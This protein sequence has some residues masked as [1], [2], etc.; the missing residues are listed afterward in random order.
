MRSINFKKLNNTA[1]YDGVYTKCQNSKTHVLDHSLHFASAV[2][3]GIRIYNYKAFKLHEHIK[4]FR[5]SAEILGFKVPY[6][7]NK[8]EKVCKTLIKKNKIANGYLR[9][10]AWRSVGSMS[11]HSINIKIK[12]FIAIWDWPVYYSEDAIKNGI[13]LTISNWRR[14]KKESAP[15]QSKCSGLYQICTMAK[16]SSYKKGFD[17]ALMLDTDDCIAETTSSNIFFVFKNKVVTPLPECFLNGITRQ[18]VIKICHKLNI[19]IEEKKIKFNQ[20]KNA[21]E[22]F[23]TGTAAEITPVRRIGRLTFNVNN[24]SITNKIFSYF[25]NNII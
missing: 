8:L 20:I 13:K 4:R 16:N 3:E 18:E 23:V 12:T 17:D 25:K 22:C 9:P 19:K 21:T 15:T 11:P 5:K 10:L 2:F 24:E 6:K 1:W 14:P 7:Q